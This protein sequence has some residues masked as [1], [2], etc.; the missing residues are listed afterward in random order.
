MQ[1]PRELV[2]AVEQALHA[3]GPDA[4]VEAHPELARRLSV[5]LACW[6]HGAVTTE[7][8]IAVLKDGQGAPPSQ[9]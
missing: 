4:R 3:Q 9:R 5:A 7:Q 6:L 2:Q 1:L 8:A